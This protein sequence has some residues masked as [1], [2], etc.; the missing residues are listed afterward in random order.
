MKL[1]ALDS[2]SA[3]CSVALFADGRVVAARDAAMDRGHAEALVPMV[4]A[5]LDDARDTCP[6][7]F[8]DLDAVAVTVG[9]GAFTGV[10]IG[11]ATAAAMAAAAGI[12]VIGLTTLEVVAAAQAPDGPPLLVALESKRADVYAQLFG[13]PPGGPLAA[14]QAILPDAIPA[15]LLPGPLALAGDGAAPVAAALRAVG[16]P[17]TA[18]PGSGRP[19]AP[20]LARLAAA[21]AA[22][23]GLPKA[24][25]RPLYLRAPDVTLPPSAKSR[26]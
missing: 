7:G 4:A 12:P 10:R 6:G 20:V 8:S 17:V 21:R 25:P 15:L 24:P 19:E 14:P 11:L 5:V 9:P 18:L 13:G 1:L 26:Q 22:R 2:A 16:I 23:D 3:A